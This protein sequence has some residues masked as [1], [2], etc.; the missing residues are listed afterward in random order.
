MEMDDWDVMESNPG[1]AFTP[2][3]GADAKSALREYRRWGDHV[4]RYLFARPSCRGR[5]VL[6]YG[7]G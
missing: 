7:W 5:T 3:S 2:R 6:D 1:A 4:N